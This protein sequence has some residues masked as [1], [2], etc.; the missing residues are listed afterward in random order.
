MRRADRKE[1]EEKN[2]WEDDEITVVSKV[3]STPSGPSTSPDEVRPQAV[4]LISTGSAD[5]R[6]FYLEERDHII[7][8]SADVDVCLIDE[9]IS[10]QHAELVYRRE[11]YVL[12]DLNSKNGT[13]LNGTEVHECPLRSGDVIQIGRHSLRFMLETTNTQ[14]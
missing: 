4:L 11:D 6:R 14:P 8:R 3:G 13:F 2:L 7:G 9:S 5:G 10:R 12:R 1:E